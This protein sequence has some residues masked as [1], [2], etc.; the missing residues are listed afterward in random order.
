[1]P[2]AVLQLGFAPSVSSGVNDVYHAMRRCLHTSDIPNFVYWRLRV[3]DV[4][5]F[6]KRVSDG[7]KAT[8]EEITQAVAEFA[9]VAQRAKEGG[10]AVTE[11]LPSPADATIFPTLHHFIVQRCRRDK[12]SSHTFTWTIVPGV[13]RS[14]T[15]YVNVL[16][17]ETD[18][19]SS[20]AA[21]AAAAQAA[22]QAAYQ[23][24]LER[25]HQRLQNA[26]Q[27]LW[28]ACD[29]DRKRGWFNTFPTIVQQYKDLW[30]PAEME[31]LARRVAGAIPHVKEGR[32]PKV[33]ALC[34]NL[35]AAAPGSSTSNSLGTGSSY[36]P[37]S[38]LSR[39]PRVFS[40]AY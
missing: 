26:L 2:R 7:R 17:A 40:R 34:S 1:M 9:A 5:D 6:V 10:Y 38:R 22:A 23:A 25:A 37:F 19:G 12:V 28:A 33:D 4:L 31:V 3:D 30:T 36:H 8:R 18:A 11:D 14:E 32:L 21:A 27:L 39:Y 20:S 29:S 15:V 24:E 35:N 16:G 13:E